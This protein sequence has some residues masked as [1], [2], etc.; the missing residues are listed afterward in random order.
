[1]GLV[2]RIRERNR[3]VSQNRQ[4]N[5]HVLTLRYVDLALE[6]SNK[7]HLKYV[8]IYKLMG[9]LKAYYFGPP[10]IGNII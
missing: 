10:C 4:E 8:D 3:N 9:W 5:G 2:K 6:L 1:M 7:G